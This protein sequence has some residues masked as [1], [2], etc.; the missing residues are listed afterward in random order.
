MEKFSSVKDV[1]C[2]YKEREDLIGEN[3]SEELS[4][5]EEIESMK[6]LAAK[7]IAQGDFDTPQTFWED[8]NK[9]NVLEQNLNG[10]WVNSNTKK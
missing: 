7:E 9:V 2:Q 6:E 4:G 8:Y 3:S 1:I 10:Y 5:I